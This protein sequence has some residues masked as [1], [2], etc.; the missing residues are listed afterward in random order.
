MNIRWLDAFIAVVDAGGVTAAS[1]QLYISPQALLQQINLLEKET[2]LKL[3]NRS[4]TGMKP[5]PAGSEFYE[6]ASTIVQAWG[7]A[8]DACRRIEAGEDPIR[9]PVMNTIMVA[10]LIETVCLRYREIAPHGPAVALVNTTVSVDCWI[11]GLLDGD[12]DM[13]EWYKP[14]SL[15]LPE[16]HYERFCS[17]ASVF[18]MAPDHALAGRERIEPEDLEGRTIITS[19]LRL[20]EGLRAHLKAEGIT[21]DISLVES[22]RYAISEACG[23]GALY[24]ADVS[25]TDRLST[26]GFQFAPFDFDMGLEM[27]FA[28]KVERAQAYRQF[29]EAVRQV[30][31]GAA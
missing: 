25:I 21:P 8:L 2:G 26:L 16:V 10:D 19:S 5:T 13:I 3:L 14:V 24:L 22:N 15:Q 9:M 31:D 30:R 11:D 17:I 20:I 18:M 6:R 12:F 28:C 4:S 29:F 1:R 7:E 27:G 23:A